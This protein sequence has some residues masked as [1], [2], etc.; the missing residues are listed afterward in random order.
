MK[1][2]TLDADA[3]INELKRRYL[4]EAGSMKLDELK[5]AN[6]DLPLKTLSNKASELLGMTLAKYLKVH[7]ILG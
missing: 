1:Y 4:N 3:V 6:P 2:V 7:G 5:S